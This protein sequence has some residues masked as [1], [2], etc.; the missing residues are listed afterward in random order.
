MSAA[1]AKQDIPK[2]LTI[3]QKM[4][5]IQAEFP[6]VGKNQSGVGIKYKY[7]G[8]DDALAHLN[9]LMA[10]H[11]VYIQIVDMTADFSEAGHTANGAPGHRCVVNGKVRFV[12]GD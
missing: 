9:G 10:K 1:Q 8:I 11:G 2:V 7:R 4:A 5:A 12:S 3:H 6:A